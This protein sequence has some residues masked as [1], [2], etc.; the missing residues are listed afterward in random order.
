MKGTLNVKLTQLL[1][2]EKLK[3]CE[4][5]FNASNQRVLR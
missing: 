5:L 2:K 4:Q 3:R 1:H